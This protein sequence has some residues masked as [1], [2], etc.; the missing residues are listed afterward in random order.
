MN[1]YEQVLERRYYKIYSVIKEVIE[2]SILI[3][4]PEKCG[5]IA[6]RLLDIF[7]Q[8]INFNGNRYNNITGNYTILDQRFYFILRMTNFTLSIIVFFSP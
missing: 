1:I 8:T 6:A 4:D 7:Y 2:I 3:L 5:T